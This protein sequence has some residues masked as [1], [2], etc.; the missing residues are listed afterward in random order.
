MNNSVQLADVHLISLRASLLVEAVD[1]DAEE[2]TESLQEYSLSVQDILD[3]LG[4]RIIGPRSGRTAI[5][6]DS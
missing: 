1:V 5:Y 3:T 2:I 6:Y 4:E